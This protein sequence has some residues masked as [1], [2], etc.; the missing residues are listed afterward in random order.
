MVLEIGRRDTVESPPRSRQAVEENRAGQAC[1]RLTTSTDRI[2]RLNS[3]AVYSTCIFCHSP[4]GS[5]EVFEDF[6]VGRRLAYD[7]ARGR[8]WVVCQQCARWNLTPVEER[9]ETIEHA[10]RLHADTRL[11][12]GS[13]SI[14]L[15]RLSD[16]VEVVRIGGPTRTELAIWRYGDAF[17][18]RRRRNLLLAG[19]VVGVGAV[20]IGSVGM[21]A[22][23]LSTFVGAQ[24]ALQV[25]EFARFGMPGRT[26][27]RLR[28]AGRETLAIN[29]LQ[30]RYSYLGQG[31]DG[32]LVLQLGASHG[33]RAGAP[34]LVTGNDAVVALRKMLPGVNRM[35]GTRD[36]IQRAIEYVTREGTVERVLE[37]IAANGAQL[38]RRDEARGLTRQMLDH[39]LARRTGLLALP[40]AISLAL[41]IALH[42]D[43]ERRALEGELRELELA[44]REA[45]EIAKIA[46]GLLLPESVELDLE[47]LRDRNSRRADSL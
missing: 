21:L 8:L 32:G 10:E 13:E 28:F 20:G 40:T 1:G 5:N 16:G 2:F 30:L 12:I 34:I 47:R 38:T 35:G 39:A 41:E 17:R 24:F 26:L 23:G 44:W 45:E 27:T 9:W 29:S 42:E 25:N 46:D 43:L 11:K 4:L 19:T 15:A 36:H 7:P 31:P 14:S 3:V 18:R 37:R 6:P 33:A 22:T